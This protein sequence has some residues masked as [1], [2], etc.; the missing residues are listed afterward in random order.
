MLTQLFFL[1]NKGYFPIPS[2]TIFHVIHQRIRMRIKNY[3]ILL[4]L[5]N[6]ISSLEAMRVTSYFSLD[7]VIAYQTFEELD[8]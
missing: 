3:N 2:T 1:Y 6:V 4:T 8:P 5:V 7:S